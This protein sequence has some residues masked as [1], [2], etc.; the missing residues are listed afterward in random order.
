MPGETAVIL[1]CNWA[2]RLTEESQPVLGGP[3]R[4]EGPPS[5]GKAEAGRIGRAVERYPTRQSLVQSYHVAAWLFSSS[6]A[7]AVGRKGLIIL[8][9]PYGVPLRS[10]RMTKALLTK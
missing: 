8:R 3:A 1:L 5:C 7:D 4:R 9:A 6:H 2:V 10:T